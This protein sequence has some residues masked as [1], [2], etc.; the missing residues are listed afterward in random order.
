MEEHL[1][2]CFGVVAKVLDLCSRKSVTDQQLITGLFD[3]FSSQRRCGEV[4]KSSCGK[5]I[6][7]LRNDPITGNA[8]ACSVSLP[9]LTKKVD[10]F[11]KK[12][13]DP[14]KIAVA[15]L[16]LLDILRQNPDARNINRA[17]FMECFPTDWWMQ[18]RK[19]CRF[20]F[21]QFLSRALLYVVRSGV[22]NRSGKGCIGF[23]TAEYIGS[24]RKKYEGEYQL[25]QDGNFVELPFLRLYDAFIE[26]LD[27]RQVVRFLLLVNTSRAFTFSCVEDHMDFAMEW[28]PFQDETI[29]IMDGFTGEKIQKF[30]REFDAYHNFLA[31]S[32]NAE[33]LPKEKIGDKWGNV[34]VQ[35]YANGVENRSPV[36][37]REACVSV[38]IPHF[39]VG[40]K[41]WKDFAQQTFHYREK[42]LNIYLELACHASRLGKIPIYE[43]RKALGG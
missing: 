23:I 15:L 14:D 16:V 29:N 38:L 2:L 5:Y 20:H 22:P 30:L 19:E 24:L 37:G 25:S 36:L 33:W 43:E 6:N 13:M 42:L 39:S 18:E 12:L 28:N 4:P 21:P 27:R 41:G 10:Q 40:E 1:H 3:C 9:V 8:D 34:D 31:C 7:C 17:V 32:C 26:E 11:V 35:C